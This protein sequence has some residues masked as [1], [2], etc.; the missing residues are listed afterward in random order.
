MLVDPSALQNLPAAKTS[1][2]AGFFWNKLSLA[3]L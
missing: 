2:A 3:K 1:P